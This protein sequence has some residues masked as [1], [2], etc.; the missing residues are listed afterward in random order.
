MLPKSLCQSAFGFVAKCNQNICQSDHAFN[1]VISVAKPNT[2]GLAKH[3]CCHDLLQREA[4][5]TRER[6][7][8]IVAM[9]A[10][11]K[12]DDRAAQVWDAVTIKPAKI[13]S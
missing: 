10:F 13:S 5:V 1:T 3:Q 4:A 11:Q 6:Q 8:T 12:R 9:G 7:D 2:V